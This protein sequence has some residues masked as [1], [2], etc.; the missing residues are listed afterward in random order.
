MLFRKSATMV[1]PDDA[2]PGRSE[3]AEL[4]GYHFPAQRLGLLCFALA[5]GRRLRVPL[6]PDSLSPEAFR[7][8]AVALA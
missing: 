7:Q 5:S 6:F 2:L 4:V 3:P 8:L 1:A